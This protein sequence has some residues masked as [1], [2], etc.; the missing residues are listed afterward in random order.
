LQRTRV[1]TTLANNMYG[2]EH[3]RNPAS[4]SWQVRAAHAA[5]AGTSWLT[6][7][8]H[9][10]SEVV[11]DTMAPRLLV[12][13]SKID[14]VW[15]GRDRARLGVR[16]PDRRAVARAEL[17]LADDDIMLLALGRHE[18]QK[19]LDVAITAMAE[20]RKTLPRA[21][22]LVAGRDGSQTADLKSQVTNMGLDGAVQ[23]LG[24]RKDVPDLLVAADM[25]VFPSRWEGLPGS[26]LEAMALAT[27]I[28]A[29]ALPN[30]LEAAT[31]ECARLVPIDDAPALASAIAQTVQDEK[32]TRAQVAAGVARF[33]QHFSVGS[34]AD[35]MVRF[36]ERALS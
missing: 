1:V 2:P 33:D 8:F 18:R 9:A 3:V 17:G 24:H 30:T 19:A 21:K 34:A 12:P 25:L 4:R 11:A 23:F 7:R 13:R 22:L 29:S 36:Y 6:R 28:V 16:S 26:V 14:V 15:R 31:D 5:D 35:G 32:G 10:V 20:V 27:P